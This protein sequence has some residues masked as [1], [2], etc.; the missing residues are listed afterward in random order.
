VMELI[1]KSVL[2]VIIA[3][4]EMPL[5]LMSVKEG[6]TVLKAA[7]NRSSA[8]VGCTSQRQGKAAVWTVQPVTIAKKALTK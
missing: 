7:L 1:L 5:R 6:I 2:K 8:R 3:L 4:E